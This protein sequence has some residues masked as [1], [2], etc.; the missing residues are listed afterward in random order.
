MHTLIAQYMSYICTLNLQR[1]DAREKSPHKLFVHFSF[2][3]LENVFF[4]VYNILK[5]NFHNLNILKSLLSFDL[6]ALLCCYIM[7][8]Y[9]VD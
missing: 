7:I 8:I 9:S 3:L 5:L 2:F 4:K 6:L 1:K